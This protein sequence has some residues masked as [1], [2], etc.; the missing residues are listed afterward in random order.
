MIKIKYYFNLY[1]DNDNN[2][3]IYEEQKVIKT[4]LTFFNLKFYLDEITDLPINDCILI[5]EKESDNKYSF[6]NS[7]HG[8]IGETIEFKNVEFKNPI[9]EESKYKIYFEFKQGGI[10]VLNTKRKPLY[11]VLHTKPTSF[12]M[13]IENSIKINDIYELQTTEQD[14]IKFNFSIKSTNILNYSF[15]IDSKENVNFDNFIP[16]INNNLTTVE[17]TLTSTMF[18]DGFTYLH[19][20]L[21][22][23]FN[24]VNYKKYKITTKNNTFTSM[25]I[26]ENE[27]KINSLEDNINIFFES[28][29]VE[30]LKP[31]IQYKDKDNLVQKEGSE[32]G[33]FNNNKKFFILNLKTI[34]GEIKEKTLELFFVLNNKKELISN[35]CLIKIDDV[36]PEI[37]MNNYF[38]IKNEKIN[39][40]K[41]EGKIKD[42]NL[43]YIGEN[44]K[45]INPVKNF[46][47]IF[48]NKNLQKI[49]FENEEKED[50]EKFNNYFTIEDKNKD[51]EVFDN[52]NLKVTDFKYIRTDSRKTFFIWLNKNIFTSFEKNL[53]ANQGN[54]KIKEENGT[55]I[56]S[57]ETVEFD[58]IILIKCIINTSV[59]DFFDFDLGVEGFD[60]SF[61]KYVNQSNIS[62]ELDSQKRL[63]T[64]FD[65]TNIILTKNE[66]TSI[67]KVN[68]NK[69][70]SEKIGIFN[71][72]INILCL[73]YKDEKFIC[74]TNSLFFD[75]D[76]NIN[77]YNDIYFIPELKLEN[78]KINFN[79]YKCKKISFNTYNF[80]IDIP[81]NEGLNNY[82]LIFKDEIEN[83]IKK[84]FIIEKNYKKTE[85]ILVNINN[86]NLYKDN[87]IYN[88]VTRDNEI[89]LEFEIINETKEIKE[90][91][92]LITAKGN[93]IIKYQKVKTGNRNFSFNFKANENKNNFIIYHELLNEKIFELTVQKK[94]ELLLECQNKIITGLNSYNFYIKKDNFS[95]ITVN[96]SNPN[97]NISIKENYLEINRLNNINTIEELDFEINIVDDKGLLQSVSKNIKAYF[98]NDNI[99]EEYHIKDSVNNI[100]K[101]SSFDLEL[102]LNSFKDIEFVRVFDEFENVLKNKL[103]YG[104]INNYECIIKNITSPV[105]PSSIKIEFKIKN[106]DIIIKQELFSDDKITLFDETKNFESSIN[107]TDLI[108]VNIKTKILD[109][110]Y[111]KIYNG[112]ELLMNGNINKKYENI[113]IIKENL[114]TYDFI[115]LE[116]F[117]NKNKIVFYER[118][119][120]NII[121]VTTNKEKLNFDELNVKTINESS[122][123]YF[124]NKEQG[125]E[126]ILEIENENGILDKI[127]LNEGINLYNN[128]N[129]G[130]Y[131]LSLIKKRFNFKKTIKS[132]YLFLINDMSERIE[133]SKGYK[134]YNII[135]TISFINNTNIN[136][137]LL[138]PNLKHITE[139]KTYIIKPEYKENGE[140]IFRFKKEKGLNKFIYKDIFG[141]IELEN[142]NFEPKA[143][144]PKIE[145][146]D[147]NTNQQSLFYIKDKKTIVLE[148]ES[149]LY[150]TCS[151][152]NEIII[153]PEKLNNEIKRTVIKDYPVTIYKEFIPCSIDFYKNNI[154]LDTYKIE[155][156]KLNKTVI[157]FWNTGN[158]R[159]VSVIP[160]KIKSTQS[161]KNAVQLTIKNRVKHFLYNFTI[162]TAKINNKTD[163][164]NWT[165]DEQ[166]EFIKDCTAKYYNE[167]HNT[168][169]DGIKNTIKQEILKLED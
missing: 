145:L 76:L 160:F 46:L 116:I 111:F 154:C 167:F 108:E 83:K 1:K 45:I 8:T 84:E 87:D 114:K 156:E 58:N 126:Y 150:F 54:L 130:S 2:N 143:T 144:I 135:N 158:K 91:E 134:R 106:T 131:K 53:I 151:E 129:I 14:K 51:F 6:N 80:E 115:I 147:I 19:F 37:E 75:N 148:S 97:F 95:R 4:N 18:K 74:K 138:E 56:L 70:L 110:Y 98:Y 103:K 31:I 82:K 124:S 123:I 101:E 140:I 119:L 109:N 12:N 5:I 52:N 62:G 113:K 146:E 55:N 85:A 157:Q 32:I 142:A 153:K 137:K 107:Y 28:R 165:L 122:N 49:K 44:V 93:D 3:I 155:I 7:I 24:N 104:K 71:N 68:D 168:N 60:Y 17:E 112:N 79:S 121:P 64:K 96:Y 15:K 88:I 125:Y 120:L 41:L 11:F 29:N 127:N 36:K 61:L 43:F 10:T 136:F 92:S 132:Y 26:L 77:N 118:K 152:A 67:L 162:F 48:S 102:K 163:F 22:D 78:K 25:Y 27:F 164:L 94:N 86:Y 69:L 50:L 166:E 23:N 39:S 21:K 65:K 90:Q 34:F 63:I 149:N 141:L 81:I 161:I 159:M 38:L 117:N 169:V 99:I 100:I 40:L 9:E 35:K 105:I 72:Y 66:K 89:N 42:D 20:C 13:N 16:I 139:N 47:L 59:G 33:T 57:Q 133:Y 73:S 30:R 128:F